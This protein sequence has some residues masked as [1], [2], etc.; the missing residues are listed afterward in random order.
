MFQIPTPGPTNA[1]GNKLFNEGEK[2]RFIG[3]VGA[4]VL[5]L[6]GFIGVF[7][8]LGDGGDDEQ[9][10]VAEQEVEQL[11]SQ[12]ALPAL[13]VDE[14]REKAKDATQP[15]R[16]VLET[17]ALDMALADARLYS[18]QHFEPMNGVDLT[19]QVGA[20]FAERSS[21]SRGKIVRVRGA[22]EELVEYEAAPGVS[23]HFR[24]RV[25]L[26]SGGRCFVAFVTGGETELGAGD[27]VMLEGF[28]FKNQAQNVPE[29]GWVEG[30]L[31]VGP[32]AV[33]SSPALGAVTSIA[34]DE[35]LDVEDDSLHG[36]FR[37]TP[38]VYWK[39]LA[40][41]R[42]FDPGSIDW[43]KAPL[44]DGDTMQKLA[45]DPASFR[46]KPMRIPECVVQDIWR[47][48]KRENPAR[49]T[50]LTEG[51]VG[52]YEWLR[53]IYPVVRFDSPAPNPGLR[54]GAQMTAR[55]F[56]LRI[57]AYESAGRG[58]QMAPLFVLAG[59]EPFVPPK[60]STLSTILAVLGMTF[61]GILVMFVLLMRRDQSKAQ[62]LNRQL[63]ERRRMRRQQTQRAGTQ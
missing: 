11:R 12:I 7:M 43:S 6:G 33:R 29:L 39:L 1:P 32:R 16:S 25:E 41:A 53:T 47:Q 31:V 35:F 20:E 60:D 9:R 8:K 62:A 42:D 30:P 51:W 55:G 50:H 54:K 61:V 26:E 44:L 10:A 3:Y 45:A 34:P 14:Y 52:S 56:F 36:G 22:L 38:P 5:V 27:F 24:G 13:R 37:A 48:A 49:L 15:E 59:M 18:P 46:G 19:P 40:Y 23:G 63:L 2:R 57:H 28:F 21:E 4:L 17:A 58:T